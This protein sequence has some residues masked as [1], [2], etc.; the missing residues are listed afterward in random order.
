MPVWE[1]FFLAALAVVVVLGIALALAATRRRKSKLLKERFGPEY[2]HAVSEVGEPRAAEKE[3]TARERARS[4]L[5]ITELSP[6]ARER[7]VATWRAVQAAFVDRPADAL[8]DADGLVTEVMRDRGYPVD[9]FERRVADISVDHPDVVE[10]F[11]SA[12]R[13]YES[14]DDGDAGT[15]DQREAF[16]HYRAL[17]EKLVGADDNRSRDDAE[18]DPKE[19]HA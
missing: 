16:V 4:K 9:D 12:R 19:A 17:F 3:L 8:R 18:T 14:Q 15:E 2:D 11:R 10:N 7:Y 5:D 13:T 6:E 1:W